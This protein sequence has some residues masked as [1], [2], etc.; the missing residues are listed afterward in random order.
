MG[1]E[2]FRGEVSTRTD[3]YAMGVMLYELL[4]GMVP[5]TGDFE[6]VRKKHQQDAP[7]VQP[8]EQRD[9]PAELI[10]V[11]ER[12]MHKRELFRFKTAKEFMRALDQCGVPA[13][14][15]AELGQYVMIGCKGDSP[16]QGPTGESAAGDS[17][18]YFDRLTQIASAKQASRSDSGIPPVETS[19]RKED[20]VTV[21]IELTCAE[22][23]Y[24]LTG[25]A[26][27]D[28]CP[29]CGRPVMRSLERRLLENADLAWLEK[30]AQGLG[31]VHISLWLALGMLIAGSIMFLVA[32]N[33]AGFD[34]IAALRRVEP[35]LAAGAYGLVL[36]FGARGAFRVTAVEPQFPLAEGTLFLKRAIRYVAGGTTVVFAVHMFLL[37]TF[38]EGLRS[39]TGLVTGLLLMFAA[40][41]VL[42][43]VRHLSLRMPEPELARG[44]HASAMLILFTGVLAV[45]GTRL[46]STQVDPS[47]G[48]IARSLAGLMLLLVGGAAWWAIVLLASVRSRTDAI[49]KH[50]RR[51]GGRE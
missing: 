49:I 37:L 14:S 12:A 48:P 46:R 1:P 33:L 20:E 38:Q 43:Y 51:R 31:Q 13:A 28:D 7:D 39:A 34:T 32:E 44:L 8:L 47:L 42:L 35:F 15:D 5:F 25:A 4:A 6:E 3:V 11:I 27:S 40:S 21:E 24:T 30:V 23:G 50:A 2:M 22:C 29:E 18:S 45:V 36:A 19:K 10:D 9:V 41:L 17:S 16:G 26:I